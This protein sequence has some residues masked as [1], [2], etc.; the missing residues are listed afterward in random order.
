MKRIIASRGVFRHWQE[1]KQGDDET[2][3]TRLET[4]KVR[5]VV[6]GGVYTFNVSPDSL[7]G[8][9]G[10]Y[11][12]DTFGILTLAEKFEDWRMEVVN[13]EVKP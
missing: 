10:N 5:P 2:L 13:V 11:T 3:A 4:G 9:G 7:Y 6:D 8:K 12:F 1:P